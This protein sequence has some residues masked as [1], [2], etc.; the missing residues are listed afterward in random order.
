MKIPD[1]TVRIT[2]ICPAPAGLKAIF[3]EGNMPQEIV[4]LVVEE[5]SVGG[6]FEHSRVVGMVTSERSES[7]FGGNL[8][9]A[10]CIDAFVGYEG[11]V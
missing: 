2:S 3:S 11:A 6:R 4:C 5:V 1:I 10:E 9:S 8:I 7:E